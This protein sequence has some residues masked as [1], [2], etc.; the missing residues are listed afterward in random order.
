MSNH[1]TKKRF[2][3]IALGLC[4]SA[5]LSGCGENRG[6]TPETAPAVRVISEITT[7]VTTEPTTLPPEEGL[8]YLVLVNRDNRLPENWETFLELEKAVTGA[9]ADCQVETQTLKHFKKLQR[10]F[11]KKGVEIVL[12]STYRSV[13]DQQA[14]L[15]DYTA[16]RGA[17]FARKYVG[18]PGYSEH[19]TGL[20]VDVWLI[21]DGEWIA[22]NE[23][24]LQA[25]DLFGPIHEALADYGFILRYPKGK[26]AVTGYA[27]EPWHFRYVGEDAAKE[28]YEKDQTLEEYL[29]DRNGGRVPGAP[30]VD[31]GSS[32]LYTKEEMDGAII[33]LKEQFMR[34]GGCRLTRIRYAGDDKC[35]EDA[36]AQINASD[37]ERAYTQCIAFLTDFYTDG[38]AAPPLEANT[39]YTDRLWRLARRGNGSW[40]IVTDGFDV[41]GER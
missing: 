20:A 14:V 24:M 23:A 36:L 11:Q 9:G 7:E 16:R 33:A 41:D 38:T 29:A 6:G 19:Q 34:T 22:T 31:Y 4:A 2:M 28:I 37:A 1:F 15:D 17:E 8:D 40:E 35:G 5:A 26:E 32:D 3:M 27:Y 21:K 10:H 18:I 13:Q 39:D 12:S 30:S 25:E